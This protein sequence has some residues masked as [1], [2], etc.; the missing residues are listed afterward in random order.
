M[1]TVSTVVAVLAKGGLVMIP[2]AVCSVLSLAVIL[3]RAWFWL[4]ARSAGIA[5]HVLQ[6]AAAGKWED[7]VERARASHAPQARVLAAGLV[8]REDGPTLAMQAM[9]KLKVTALTQKPDAQE[10]TL[11]LQDAT[12]DLGL[13]FVIPMNEANRLAHACRLGQIKKDA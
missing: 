3:E 11:L 5:E 4:R 13:A 6:L 7:A 12:G 10:A 8:H 2:L 1:M 9:V